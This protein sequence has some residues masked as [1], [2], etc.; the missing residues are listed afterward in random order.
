MGSCAVQVVSSSLKIM[1]V[2]WRRHSFFIYFE[3]A[4]FTPSDVNMTYEIEFK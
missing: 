1:P 4:M 2:S 3:V